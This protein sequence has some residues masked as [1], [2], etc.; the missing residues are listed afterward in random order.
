MTGYPRTSDA[1]VRVVR[2]RIKPELLP[3]QR[4]SLSIFELLDALASFQ[5]VAKM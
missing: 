3:E 1:K 5:P 4:D 2:K